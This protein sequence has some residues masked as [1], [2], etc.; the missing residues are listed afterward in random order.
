MRIN[1]ILTK[2]LMIINLI[3]LGVAFAIAFCNK[4]MNGLVKCSEECD[5]YMDEEFIIM[6]RI[7]G[8]MFVAGVLVLIRQCMSSKKPNYI[9]NIVFGV[10]TAFLSVNATTAFAGFKKINHGDYAP[11]NAMY[12]QQMDIGCATTYVAA[13]VMIVLVVTSIVGIVKERKVK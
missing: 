2:C 12:L 7:T 8:I 9:M 1:N 10:I 5:A 11:E 13:L 3:L 6:L 4:D